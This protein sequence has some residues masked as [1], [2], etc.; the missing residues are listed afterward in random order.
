MISSMARMNGFLHSIEYLRIEPGFKFVAES[1]S[2]R[3]TVA[4]IGTMNLFK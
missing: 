4:S 2:A 3:L 1:H